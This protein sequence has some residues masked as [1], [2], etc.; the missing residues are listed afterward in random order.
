MK[1]I[2]KFKHAEGNKLYASPFVISFNPKSYIIKELELRRLIELENKKN[3]ELK[4]WKELRT[5]IAKLSDK[6]EQFYYSNKEDE[7]NYITLHKIEKET[8]ITIY[9]LNVGEI[10]YLKS[11][12]KKYI[13]NSEKNKCHK[14]NLILIDCYLLMK[15]KENKN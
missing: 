13:F 6:P 9:N 15:E 3:K 4:L 10:N 11:A 12:L 8:N 14:V 7:I 5:H 2:R 1:S